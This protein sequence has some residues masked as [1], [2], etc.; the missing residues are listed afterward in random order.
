[1]SESVRSLER[2]VAILHVLA[3]PGAKTAVTRLTVKW[4]WKSLKPVS[5]ANS[6]PTVS[7]PT[8]GGPYKTTS[9]ISL[10]PARAG[11]PFRLNREAAKSNDHN[12]RPARRQT[13]ACAARADHYLWIANVQHRLQYVQ[14]AR[15]CHS[16]RMCVCVRP[17]SRNPSCR[18][19]LAAR[20]KWNVPNE[21][22]RHAHVPHPSTGAGAA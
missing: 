12:M 3:D 13:M 4:L 1:M 2:A 17:I 14:L 16:N 20:F 19:R 18:Y 15:S 8:P 11:T 9:R 22:V 6:L 7:L 5:A 21:P 10:P